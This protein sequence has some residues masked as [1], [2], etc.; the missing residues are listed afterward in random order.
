MER[1]C[2]Q[3]RPNGW[4]SRRSR[5]NRQNRRSRLGLRMCVK[6]G[7]YTCVCVCVCVCVCARVCIPI[8]ETPCT[9]FS[10]IHV[11]TSE[12]AEPAEPAEPT[13][14]TN[15]CQKWEV[16]VCVC[17]CVCVYVYRFPRL[18][19]LP[20]HTSTCIH[21]Y[22]HIVVALFDFLEY[23]LQNGRVPDLKLRTAM[24]RRRV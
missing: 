14:S 4:R 23:E 24:P 3:S 19:A 17:V 10:H 20:F 11:H 18:H 8:L 15:V 16:H 21:L 9:P 6:S 5:Q 13:R 1:L 12:P 22:T 2:I 7:K